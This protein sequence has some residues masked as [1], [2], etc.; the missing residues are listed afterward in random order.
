MAGKTGRIPQTF[1]DQLLVRVDIA[2]VIDRRVPLTRKGKRNY[3]NGEVH[4]LVNS[5]SASE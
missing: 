4:F 2:D 1:I 5:L 3:I